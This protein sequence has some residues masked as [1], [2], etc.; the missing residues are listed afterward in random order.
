[1]HKL[2]TRDLG[3]AVHAPMLAF[4]GGHQ[5]QQTIWR[6]LV[7]GLILEQL[8]QR[9]GRCVETAVMADLVEIDARQE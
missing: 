3:L 1:V 4:H 6:P 8:P 5:R 7:V 2:V 9:F